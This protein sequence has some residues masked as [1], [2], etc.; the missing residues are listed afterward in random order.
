MTKLELMQIQEKL[1]AA[2]CNPGAID[3]I[4]GRNTRA[5]ISTYQSKFGLHITGNLDSATMAKLGFK[6]TADTAPPWLSLARTKLGL[7]ET[8]K[9]TATFLKS[10]GRTLGDPAVLPWCGDF[11]ET[12]VALTVPKE[13]L[14]AN[15]YYALN[16]MKFGIDAGPGLRLGAIAVFK[17]DGGGHVG[18][19]VGHDDAYIHV[20]GGNQDN[21]VKVSKISRTRLQGFRWPIHYPMPSLVLPYRSLEASI[22]LNER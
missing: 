8:Q 4:M 1:K 12:C 2:G 10:D 20:L 7:I 18:F 13:V 22:S 16:W 5:A 3:G 6:V 11:V 19:A 14:P 17:R 21:M 9:A 15:P